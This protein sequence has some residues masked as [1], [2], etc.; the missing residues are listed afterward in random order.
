MYTRYRLRRSPRSRPTSAQRWSLYTTST[1]LEDVGCVIQS[2]T[3]SLNLILT[4]FKS[5]LVF[6]EITNC[7]RGSAPAGRVTD[8]R[9]PLPSM[10]E[11]LSRRIAN[12]RTPLLDWIQVEVTTRCDAACTYCPHTNYRA[13]WQSR[14]MSPETFEYL[15]PAF[16]AT[17]LI[18][19]QGWGEPLLGPHLREMARAAKRANCRVGLTTNGS[20]LDEAGVARLLDMA[21]DVVAL[22]LAGTGPGHGRLRPG[23]SV[24]AVA[25]AVRELHRQRTERQMDA[26]AVHI[27]YLLTRSGLDELDDLAQWL[28]DLPVDEV[29]VSTLDFVPSP[30]LEGETLRPKTEE[31]YAQLR[32]R[33]DAVRDAA[34]A[35]GVVVHGRIAGPGSPGECTENVGGAVF[36][37]ASGDVSPCVFAN[38]PAGDGGETCVWGD[39]AEPLPRLV[40]GNVQERPLGAIW[41]SREYVDFRLAM[42]A[43][44]PPPPCVDCPKRFLRG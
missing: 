6:P 39:R 16:R 4:H 22:S 43:G 37:S 36:V 35:H 24:S 21:P 28:V 26:P 17:R 18:Y 29:V 41:R 25:R 33:L 15:V 10:R 14:D 7:T 31:E 40:F 9:R 19:L 2:A 3:R 30:G 12:L 11:R 34:A 32:A 8:R 42:A 27:A 44:D 5:P 1:N 20:A 38:L 23:T 13:S